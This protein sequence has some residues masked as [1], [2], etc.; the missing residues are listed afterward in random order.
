MLSSTDSLIRIIF[1]L[2]LITNQKISVLFSQF[3]LEEWY[4]LW[5]PSVLIPIT[6]TKTSVSQSKKKKFYF[7]KMCFRI[8]SRFKKLVCISWHIGVLRDENRTEAETVA[9]AEGSCCDPDNQNPSSAIQFPS[10]YCDFFC[11]ER[12]K[13]FPTVVFRHYI[14]SASSETPQTVAHQASLSMGLLR[15]EQQV[16]CHFLLQEIFLT[17][18]SNSCLLKV[19]CILGGNSSI[20]E[21]KI[22]P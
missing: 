5:F 12:G 20:K 11:L 21:M 7:L 19:S 22:V 3:Q 9:L 10:L 15:Q 18:G 1:L 2:L 14:T 17:Q 16:G 13:C 4:L 6:V 8:S